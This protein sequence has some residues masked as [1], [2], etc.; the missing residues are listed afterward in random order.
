MTAEPQR[1]L[2]AGGTG[3][4]GRRAVPLLLAAGHEVHA[5]ARSEA[6]VAAAAALGARPVHGDLLDAT[7]V[8]GVVRAV[9]PTV[10]VHLATALAGTRDLAPTNRLRIDGTRH[11]VDAAERAHAQRVVAQSIAFAYAPG[12]PGPAAEDDPLDLDAADPAWRAAVAA[13]KHLED[14]TLAAG[15]MVAVVLR[16]GLLYG[17]GT[18]FPDGRPARDRPRAFVHVD[19]AADALARAVG[20][21]W[22]VYN[23]ADDASDGAANGK[24]KTELGWAPKRSGLHTEEGS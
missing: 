15:Q 24:A 6:S 14:T 21:G 4:I 17:P 19:D 9:R 7:A 12:T 2:V 13:V 3:A 5:L 18:A 10:V 20:A 1:V 16:F 22:G 8:A 11:L 23:V